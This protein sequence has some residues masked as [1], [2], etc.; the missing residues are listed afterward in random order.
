MRA[1]GFPRPCIP[2]SPLV[3][4]QQRLVRGSIAMGGCE[5]SRQACS[6]CLGDTRNRKVLRYSFRSLAATDVR[7]ISDEN[8]PFGDDLTLSADCLVLVA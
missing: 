5:A 6:T 1:E 8:E 4:K 3:Q 7:L 2:R